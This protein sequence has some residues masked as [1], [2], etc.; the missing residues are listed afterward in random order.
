MSGCIFHAGEFCIVTPSSRI[1]LQFVKTN[2][3]GLRK[4]FTFLKSFTVVPG[5]IVPAFFSFAPL[6]E[7]SE[8][9]QISVSGSTMPPEA[10]RFFH[11]E[12]VNLLF[13]TIL[14]AS[15]LPSIIPLPVI[16]ILVSSFP[17]IGFWFLQAG[18]RSQCDS[19]NLSS[20]KS[21]ANNRTASF[22]RCRLTLLCISIGPESQSPEGI[23]TTPPPWSLHALIA[24]FIVEVFR[25]WPS[26]LAP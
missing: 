4:S 9:Y 3:L 23:R 20:S 13:L 18:S 22:L 17:D 12:A 16:A 19:T 5:R 8:G 2:K 6:S 24:R 15:P 7:L 26:P 25:N 21:L 1:F 11:C 14:Q 10:T